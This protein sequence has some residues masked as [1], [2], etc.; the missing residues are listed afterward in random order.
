M[1]ATL[2]F[3]VM[4]IIIITT[5]LQCVTMEFIVGSLDRCRIRSFLSNPL[6]LL[7]ALA[8]S[9][10]LSS[11]YLVSSPLFRPQKVGFPNLQ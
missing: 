1:P 6:C 3:A 5:R 4:I 9:L 2:E 10:A 8:L 11:S 7:V